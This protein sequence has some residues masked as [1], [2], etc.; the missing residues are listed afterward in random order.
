MTEELY[1][2]MQDLSRWLYELQK[3][4]LHYDANI[5]YENSNN[6]ENWHSRVLRMLFEYLDGNEHPVLNSFVS[7]MKRKADLPFL[8]IPKSEFVMCTNEKFR[9]DLLVEMDYDCAIIIEN[10]INWA[11]DQDCQIE[12]YVEQVRKTPL[13]NKANIYVVYLT[14][15]GTKNVEDYS[16]TEKAKELLS[17]ELENEGSHFLSLSFAYDILPWLENDVLP[18]IK[19]KSYILLSSVT[20]YTDLLKSMFKRDETSQTIT[21]KLIRKMEEKN[22]KME[23]LED[24]FWAQEQAAK[25]AESVSLAKEQKMKTVAERCITSPLIKYLKELDTQLNLQTAEYFLGYFNIIITHPTWSKCRIHIGIWNYKNYGGLQYLDPQGN[26]LQ[27]EV[28]DELHKKFNGWKGDNNEPIWNYFE[29]GYRSY[30]TLETW[31]IIE[32]GIFLSYIESFIKEIY[33]KVQGIEI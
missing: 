14:A 20:L 11:I 24:V 4:E 28:L 32:N 2:N 29:N 30:Y 21:T 18:N 23:S 31:H 9:I 13:Q 27:P 7:L 19:I 25:F 22:I 26:A 1:N 15:D 6:N 12:R 33:D 16:L 17:G 8:N 10:K 5:L 3:K